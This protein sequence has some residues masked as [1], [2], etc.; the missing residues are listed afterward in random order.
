MNYDL[1]KELED[2]GFGTGVT[3]IEMMRS[4][5]ETYYPTLTELIKAC[6]GHAKFKLS[7]VQKFGTWK[8]MIADIGAT[9]AIGDTPEE[10]VARLWLAVNK[11]V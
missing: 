8:A 10:A 7:W 5:K 9:H 11:R 3:H 6:G 2:A 1:A 4:E